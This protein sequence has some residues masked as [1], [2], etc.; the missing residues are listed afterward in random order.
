MSGKEMAMKAARTHV[1]TIV[2]IV[3]GA[4]GY[5]MHYLPSQRQAL[6]DRNFRALSSVSVVVEDA[7][8]NVC[9]SVKNAVDA[10]D[11][12]L[13]VTDAELSRSPLLRALHTNTTAIATVNATTGQRVLV[14]NSGETKPGRANARHAIRKDEVEG[15]L[16]QVVDLQS[17]Q[18]KTNPPP[19][20]DGRVRVVLDTNAALPRLNL[21]FQASI[22]NAPGTNDDQKVRIEA[23]GSVPLNAMLERVIDESVFDAI[24]VTDSAG[25]ICWQ[26]GGVSLP[27][28][29]AAMAAGQRMQTNVSEHGGVGL[30]VFGMPLNIVRKADVSASDEA[31][32]WRWAI[33]G[34][35]HESAF[36]AEARRFPDGLVVWF[37]LVICMAVFSWPLLNLVTL[38]RRESIRLR[39]ILLLHASVFALLG[40]LTLWSCRLFAEHRLVRAAE[41]RLASVARE[42]Q[43]N[44]VGEMARIGRQ[45]KAVD[46]LML[47]H[48]T[49]NSAS[50]TNR[51]RILDAVPGPEQQVELADYPDLIRVGWIFRRTGQQLLKWTVMSNDTPLVSVTDRDYFRVIAR[52]EGFRLATTKDLGGDKPFYLDS[53]YSSNTGEHLATFSRLSDVDPLVV[54]TVDCRLV[55]VSRAV[56]PHRMGFCILDRAGRTL[57]HSDARKVQ[58]ENFVDECER[59]DELR[60]ALGAG[61]KRVIRVRYQGEDHLASLHPW[62][63]TG[64]T[65]VTFEPAARHEDPLWH[66][67]YLAALACTACTVALGGLGLAW[68]LFSGRAFE[69]Q[70]GISGVVRSMEWLRPH[71]GEARACW[72]L[73]GIHVGLAVAAWVFGKM[74]AARGFDWVPIV[75]CPIAG[76]AA[77]WAWNHSRSRRHGVTSDSWAGPEA[78]L[79]WLMD[80]RASA[81][82]NTTLLLLTSAVPVWLVFDSALEEEIRLMGRQEQV[83]LAVAIEGRQG[84]IYRD[85]DK[86]PVPRKW[87]LATN[88]DASATAAGRAASRMT[89]EQHYMR[90]TADSSDIYHTLSTNR[91]HW[92][93]Q[94]ASPSSPS[95]SAQPR[96]HWLNWLR[97][98]R[99]GFGADLDG[100][101]GDMDQ[102]VWQW[103]RPDEFARPWTLPPMAY[104]A[105]RVPFFGELAGDSVSNHVGSF[106]I[107]VPALEPVGDDPRWGYVLLVALGVA[108][109]AGCIHHHAGRSLWYLEA[110]DSAGEEETQTGTAAGAAL[111]REMLLGTC[112][113]ALRQKAMD[114]V[115]EFAPGRPVR[116]LDLMADDTARDIMAGEWP[117]MARGALGT[118][119]MLNLDATPRACLAEPGAWT[120]QVR[121]LLE[122]TRGLEGCHVIVTSTRNPL[123]W[124]MGKNEEDV[125]MEYRAWRALF[126]EWKIRT[127]VPAE[128]WQG[129][130]AE[131][132]ACKLWDLCSPGER[133]VL[134]NLA[135]GRAV[136]CRSRALRRLLAPGRGILSASGRLRFID[137]E[138]WQL[139]KRA[140]LEPMQTS[141]LDE[142]SP[143]LWER[144]RGPLALGLGLVAVFLYVTQ[145][146]TFNLAAASLTGLG[147][148]LLPLLSRLE[149][150]WKPKEKRSTGQ[151]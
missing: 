71:A 59:D 143:Q 64:W 18:V 22:G 85:W 29:L 149:P 75:G 77:W 110:E 91:T 32:K 19:S 36:A 42:I 124:E 140:Q 112:R 150:F 139:A 106:T 56:M 98:G 70:D 31:G 48:V 146:E 58:R 24:L 69:G 74:L 37:V 107:T 14:R 10:G 94:S 47:S 116:E 76:V 114:T 80:V 33:I 88:G 46:A 7:V 95:E 93:I 79:A 61:Q 2:L 113:D 12:D 111:R 148:T 35:Q 43:S 16:R 92:F 72:W 26:R 84:Q 145:R 86:R 100:L 38:H 119:V 102:S 6:I 3:V 53:I 138:M 144:V 60:G 109:L 96:R 141:G 115:S 50:A 20:A 44:L 21:T 55:S 39:T 17:P 120:R 134:R 54:A 63:E 87:V 99:H 132:K 101:S 52:G 28:Y 8:A 78:R 27:P 4:V 82:C 126:L 133:W 9:K 105:A 128:V 25:S 127:L 13:E 103:R 136:R 11:R 15:W 62:K 41:G 23:T 130:T 131:W 57:F 121:R 118:L 45:L 1:A 51:T 147:A 123:N 151:G 108:A 34:V 135:I 30:R 49:N 137:R 125:G 40:T 73:A 65:V 81:A 66:A 104:T 129:R 122:W 89:L 83:A 67:S 90:R 117:S 142:D 68:F 5:L 97:R